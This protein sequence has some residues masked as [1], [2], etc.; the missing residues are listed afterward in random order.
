MPRWRLKTADPPALDGRTV[1]FRD[2]GSGAVPSEAVNQHA[3]GAYQGF[4]R[5]ALLLGL[6]VNHSYCYCGRRKFRS[7]E[8]YTQIF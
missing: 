5:G 2:P 4:E 1:P 6:G 7:P 3:P 8:M